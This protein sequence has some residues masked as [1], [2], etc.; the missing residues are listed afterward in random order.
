MH[1]TSR[2]AEIEQRFPGLLSAILKA[3]G[4]QSAERARAAKRKLAAG[5]KQGS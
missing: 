1:N 4:I 3:H 5:R 2:C